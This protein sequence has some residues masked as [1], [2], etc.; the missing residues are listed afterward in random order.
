MLIFRT[1]ASA[2]TGFGHLKRSV[3]LASLLKNKIDILFCVNKDK[4]VLRFL[5]D[6]GTPYCLTKDLEKQEKEPGKI[7]SVVFDLREF[8]PEDTRFLERAKQKKIKTVQV[9]DLGLSQQPVDYTIDASIEKLFPYEKEKQLLDGPGYALLHQKFRHFN[10]VKRKYRK[11][12]KNVFISLGGGVQYR[13]LKALTDFLNRHRFNIKTAA[14]FY[15]K[16]S[17][18]KALKRLYPRLRFVGK[19][20]NL[21]RSFFETDV[22]VITAGTAAA[23][24]AAVGTPA[25]YL[26]YHK[27]QQFIAQSFEKKGTGLEISNIDDLLKGKFLDILSSLTLEKRIDMG[28]KGKQL[29]DGNGACRIVEFFQQEGII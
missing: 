23:E 15:L 24:A 3:Y 10:K 6:R 21:A 11:T 13:Q 27:E 17:A 18:R 26:H 22:A 19:T 25:L 29:V 2:E 12:V 5:E 9:T 1:D 8:S 28:N 16:K 20:D 4:V 7:K 14:G